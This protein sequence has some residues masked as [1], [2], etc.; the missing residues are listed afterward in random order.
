ME[1]ATDKNP[2]SPKRVRVDP[3]ATNA[4]SKTQS[5]LACAH[6]SLQ[7]YITSLPPSTASILLRLARNHLQLRARLHN[8]QTQIEKMTNDAAFLPRSARVYFKLS[9]S[10]SAEQEAEFQTLQTETALLVDKFQRDLKEKITKA[11]KIETKLLL[12]QLN[13]DLAVSLR[14]ATK[15]LLLTFESS[16]DPDR[17]LANILDNFSTTFLTY[18]ETNK[19][20]FQTLYKTRHSLL[21]F[22]NPYLAPVHEVP[23]PPDTQATQDPPNTQESQASADSTDTD[24]PTDSL[25][26]DEYRRN[27]A[28]PPQAA[29]AAAPN[30]RPATRTVTGPLPFA[31]TINKV[32]RALENIFVL[33]WNTFLTQSKKN[34]TT[35]ALKKLATD[36]FDS[37]ATETAAMEIDTEPPAR[38]ELIEEMVQKAVDKQTAKLNSE[39]GRLRSQLAAKNSNR[40]QATG[41]NKTKSSAP[42]TANRGR[43]RSQKRAAAKPNATTAASK[44]KT[45]RSKNSNKQSPSRSK[46]SNSNRKQSSRTGTRS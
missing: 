44:N 21:V 37:S 18:L 30:A 28:P 39:V 10:K 23:I 34:A 24:E 2:G 46:N 33:P 42:S 14:V 6:E 5:P 12:T 20:T 35:L 32:K 9:G 7:E 4:A 26:L 38:R 43:S 3:N 19:E 36:H 22:P 8:K 17:I 25:V 11:T 31:L 40:G 45:P 1:Q 15:A 29:A 13:E 41:A 16:A 27:L